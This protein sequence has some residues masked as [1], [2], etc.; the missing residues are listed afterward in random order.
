MTRPESLPSGIW[1]HYRHHDRY[2]VIGVARLDSDDDTDDELV[3]VYT[4]LYRRD[5]VPM[6]ARRL[7]SF[8]G[9]VDTP[10]GPVPRFRYVGLV[11]S[12]DS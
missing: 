8:L 11:D 10:N 12:A 7:E 1:E 9:N 3:V 6:T 5:G 2:F 4:R